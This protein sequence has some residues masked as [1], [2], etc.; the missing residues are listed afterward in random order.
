MHVNVDDDGFLTSFRTTGLGTSKLAMLI[1]AAFGAML[2]IIFYRSP[3]MPP[4]SSSAM[5][6]VRAV[7]VGL[8]LIAVFVIAVLPAF[9]LRNY[10]LVIGLPSATGVLLISA[11]SWEYAIYLP[12]RF[13]IMVASAMFG[14]WL[15]YSCTRLPPG[16]ILTFCGTSQAIISAAVVQTGADSAPSIFIHLTCANILGFASAK[17]MEA[18]ERELYVRRKRLVALNSR[19]VRREADAIRLSEQNRNLVAL[20][21]HDLRQPVAGMNLYLSML[22]A[23]SSDGRCGNLG[24]IV[25][26][27]Q[28]CT[29][30]LEQSLDRVM[31]PFEDAVCVVGADKGGLVDINNLMQRVH[32]VFQSNAA[33]HQVLF[34]VR[35]DHSQKVIGCSSEP[36]L[37]S[38][39]S[40]LIS[41]SIKFR[42]TEG[43]SGRSWVLVNC[44]R[45]GER[46]RID[47]ADNGIG[48]GSLH[49]DEIFASGVRLTGEAVDS[50]PSYG[51]GLASVKDA[52]N[53]LSDHHLAVRSVPG[54]GTR[55]RLYL[56]AADPGQ[57]HEVQ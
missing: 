34:R 51:L 53:S 28:A 39:V 6:S 20:V 26:S 14:Y 18:R 33:A 56:P 42:R 19:L 38:I 8:L 4:G 12:E 45:L 23:E 55:I 57:R 50:Y 3:V 7:S 31:H 5:Q 11:G 2:L 30:A 43:I 41:N 36:L 22:K 49:N 13:P 27:I 29:I 40:N 16:I 10:L 24:E 52:M 1:A 25:A 9:A 37:W 15:C 47:V 46:I 21:G 44:V 48:F 32:L 35:Y 54:S 17:H